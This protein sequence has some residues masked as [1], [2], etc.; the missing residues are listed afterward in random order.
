M[1]VLI[2]T[3]IIDLSLVVDLSSIKLSSLKYNNNNYI[4]L[5]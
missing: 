4:K 3:V 2:F 1:N 5:D